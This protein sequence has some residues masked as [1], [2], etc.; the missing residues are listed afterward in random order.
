[1]QQSGRLLFEDIFVSDEDSEDYFEPK[2]IDKGTSLN[3]NDTVILLSFRLPIKVIRKEDGSFKLEESKSPIYPAI[4]KLRNRGLNF[5]WLGWPGIIPKDA[6][7]EDRIRKLMASQKCIPIFFDQETL[8]LI[9]LFMDM[10][11]MPLFYSFKGSDANDLDE[12]NLDLWNAYKDI[13]KK[14]VKTLIDIK[15]ENDIVWINN[16]YLMLAPMYLKRQ[17]I[18]ANIGFYLHSPFPSI[19]IYTVFQYR[20]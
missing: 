19:D 9:N 3:I 10:F 7:E 8:L 20:T 1:M 16:I 12:I 18:E 17:N 6:D 5:M 15:K 2:F 14:F 4:F 11:L 13:N